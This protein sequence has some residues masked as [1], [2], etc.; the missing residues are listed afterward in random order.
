MFSKLFWH[1]KND[2]QTQGLQNGFPVEDVPFRPGSQCEESAMFE[3]LEEAYIKGVKQ[4]IPL[5]VR[6]S[7][8]HQLRLVLYPMIY[9]VWDTSQ[10]VQDFLHQ[11]YQ[12]NATTHTLPENQHSFWKS[13]VGRRAFWKAHISRANFLFWTVYNWSF[14]TLVTSVFSCNP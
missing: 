6:K 7:C 5:M 10:V 8:V 12:R 1:Q 11:E 13:I 9:K 2:P 14:L 3:P 4:H